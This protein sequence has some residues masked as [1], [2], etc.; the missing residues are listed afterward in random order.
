MFLLEL[1]KTYSHIKQIEFSKVD[2]AGTWK[3]L[4]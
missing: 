3:L 4:K 2:K 1:V